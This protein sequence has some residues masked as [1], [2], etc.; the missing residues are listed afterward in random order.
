MRHAAH[1]TA[2]LVHGRHGF[3]R[4]PVGDDGELGHVV[5]EP[6]EKLHA[7]VARLFPDLAYTLLVDVPEIPVGKRAARSAPPD[8]SDDGQ[9][10]FRRRQTGAGPA[11][12]RAGAA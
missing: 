9:L 11:W 3:L 7:E 10:H 4:R 6:A 12:S 8:P 5:V 2:A 1:V